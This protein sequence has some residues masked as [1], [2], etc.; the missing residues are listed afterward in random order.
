MCL[1][2]GALT[3]CKNK[4]YTRK[5]AWNIV[6]FSHQYRLFFQR[7]ASEFIQ[8]SNISKSTDQWIRSTRQSLIKVQS[9]WASILQT[10]KFRVSIWPDDCQNL[11][12]L[13]LLLVDFTVDFIHNASPNQSEWK[14]L[15]LCYANICLEKLLVALY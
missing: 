12:L 2:T 10:L 7:V 13:T 14:K 4:I 3:K 9:H 11:L 15:F 8:V 1:P 5:G 6:L